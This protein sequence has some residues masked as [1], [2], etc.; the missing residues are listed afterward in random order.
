[1]IKSI[2]FYLPQ[3]HPIPENDLWWG[4]GFTEWTNVS[5][6]R[7][8]FQSHYQP[9]YPAD[10]GYYDLRV[11]EVREQQAHLAGHYGLHGFIYYSYWF[12]NGKQLLQRPL[13]E[14]V[15]S[16]KPDL[17]F[18]ICW[19][20]EKWSGVWHGN[21][22]KILIEQS[23]LG[24]KDYENYF[25]TLLPSFSDRRYIRI[26][27]KP[28]FCIYEPRNIPDIHVFTNTFRKLALKNGIGEIYI[29]ASKLSID[30]NPHYFGC[31]GVIASDFSHLRYIDPK[32]K[33]KKHFAD[34]ISQ[35]L[36]RF[37]GNV[38]L[39]FE[40]RHKPLIV[41]YKTLIDYL[42]Y[43]NKRYQGFDYFPL[44]IPNWDNS[45][46]SGTKS[47]I[48]KDSSPEL[49]GIHLND[50]FSYYRNNPEITLEKQIVFI[51]SWNEWAEGNYLEPDSVY[52]HRY[53]Q[54]HYRVIN[55]YR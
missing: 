42:S 32:F 43:Q 24:E 36:K 29:L 23:Y 5:K 44:V 33:P 27:D 20:N 11:P 13:Q 19:A 16:G 41:N 21:P 54:E 46:R 40:L 45:P 1:M 50:A 8:L 3:Y 47:L 35:C 37:S 17:P 55:Q 26:G 12:G 7:P 22:N 51:K 10:L 18:C 30:Q 25:Y 6:A 34:Y 52:G 4:K 39:N 28:L 38:N 15:E 49:W 53:L 14:V 2:A 31:D 48:F 9:R